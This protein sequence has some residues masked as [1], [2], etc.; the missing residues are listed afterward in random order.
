MAR[1][2]QLVLDGGSWQ[3]RRVLPADYL[4]TATTHLVDTGS[5]RGARGGYGYLWW[6]LR[7]DGADG[8]LDIAHANG[9]AV[10]WIVTD[11]RC[12]RPA[13]FRGGLKC[14]S[15]NRSGGAGIAPCGGGRLSIFC[16]GNR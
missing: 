1:L 5:P 9:W 6:T 8:P 14:D 10:P 12:T 4:R 11:C 3:G 16:R 13:T 7:M 15:L 2:G